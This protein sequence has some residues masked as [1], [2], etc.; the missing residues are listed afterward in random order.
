[1][2]TNQI[3]QVLF[4]TS[5]GLFTAFTSSAW[6]LNAG[7]AAP[8]VNLTPMSGGAPIALSSMKGKVLL[9]DFW[10]SW[11]PPCRKSF[12]LYNQMQK[13][14]G[15][16]KF[17]VVGINVD[18]NVQDAKDFLKESP[19]DFP[20][21]ADSKGEM[22]EKFGVQGMPTSYLVDKNGVVRLVHQ[23]FKDG[24]LELLKGEITKLINQ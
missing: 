5:F 9:V 15:A 21:F 10:A 17:E 24:D 22:P 23:G 19:V 18:E 3:K 4:A 11:C 6:A 1:M 14:L 16:N 13:E 12:P 8:A 7:D 2:N 20:I